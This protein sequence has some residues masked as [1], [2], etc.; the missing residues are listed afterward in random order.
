MYLGRGGSWSMFVSSLNSSNPSKSMSTP[1]GFSIRWFQTASSRWF[2]GKYS[3]WIN[4][5]LRLRL[6]FDL[7][8][9]N[10]TKKAASKEIS[11]S[12]DA[13]FLRSLVQKNVLPI[14]ARPTINTFLF[15]LIFRRSSK[16]SSCE[17]SPR[18]I[19]YIWSCSSLFSVK[20]Y[21]ALSGIAKRFV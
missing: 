8:L 17:F 18:D 16:L 19:G 7:N 11:A 6:S 5:S 1:L 21:V 10:F 9:L 2:V 12:G 14:P 13:Q 20:S 15:S 4:S 3:D